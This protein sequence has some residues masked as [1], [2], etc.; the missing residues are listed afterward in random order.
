MGIRFP[1]C[2]KCEVRFKQNKLGERPSI[3]DSHAEVQKIVTHRSK[4]NTNLRYTR[5]SEYFGVTS[6]NAIKGRHEVSCR[7]FFF[8]LIFEFEG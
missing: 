4:S 2:G 6:Y 1:F 8:W 5:K 3:L 7:V